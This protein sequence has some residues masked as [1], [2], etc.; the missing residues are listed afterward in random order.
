MRVV[1]VAVAF[2]LVLAA[3]G[4]D[5]LPA[6][7]VPDPTPAGD[8]APLKERLVVAHARGVSI[9]NVAAGK[10]ERDLPHGIMSPDQKTFWAVEP[11]QRTT[12]IRKLD[13]ATGTELAKY[14][15]TGSYDLPKAYGPLADAISSNGRFLTLVAP[16]TD[17]FGF[18]VVD[19]RDGSERGSARLRGTFT[20]DAIDDL[21]MSL[22]LLE[23]P[24]PG[25]HRY[26][27]RLY[28]LGTRQLLPQAIVDAK[29]AQ[30]T[31]ADLARGTMG[32]IYHAST[33]AGQWHLGLYVSTTRGPVVHALN[34]TAR[35]AFC[36]IE[37]ANMSTHR[38]AWAIVPA[39][40]SGRAFAV[41]AATGAFAS[42]DTTTL[43]MATR[44]FRVEPGRDGDLRG[45]AVV[46]RDGSRLYATGGRGVLVI[47]AH[48]LTLKAQLLTEREL[49]SVM[50][51]ADGHELYVLD[52][53]GVVS[54]IDARSGEDLGVIARLPGA[55]GILASE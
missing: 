11:G 46:S 29:A 20:F 6:G 24:Q 7:T 1:A 55:V 54:R 35:W 31:P 38:A 41:N 51:S 33:T 40:S 18:T 12:S 45:S 4:R 30:P 42:I 16:E 10:V 19:L 53:G 23:Y 52:R 27:V 32:G 14:A 36:L 15:V 50:V 17:A 22:Y 28:D 26:N 49:A 43:G 21:G 5:P 37:L 39:P 2:S 8:P 44:S 13:P 25:V 34:M 48:T 3:C 47:D 9:V